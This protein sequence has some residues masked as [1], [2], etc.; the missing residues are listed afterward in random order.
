MA[1]Q[2][3]PARMPVHGDCRWHRG[4]AAAWWLPD[5]TF[6][7]DPCM[8]RRQAI[9]EVIDYVTNDLPGMDPATRAGVLMSMRSFLANRPEA[10]IDVRTA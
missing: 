2:G 5:G 7:C 9:N 6:L 3:G 4:R 10:N 8:Y 1:G